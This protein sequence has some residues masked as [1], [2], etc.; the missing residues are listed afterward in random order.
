[1]EDTAAS[2]NVG[3]ILFDGVSVGLPARVSVAVGA[4]GVEYVAEAEYVFDRWETGG[5]VPV[6]NSSANN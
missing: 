2:A 4:Y 1:M 5:L 3:L 6:A